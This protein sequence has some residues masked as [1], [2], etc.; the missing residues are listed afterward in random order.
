MRGLDPRIH[1]DR[2]RKQ[3]YGRNLGGFSCI[4]GSN[5]AMTKKGIGAALPSPRMLLEILPQDRVDARLIA[6]S[7][8]AEPAQH[9]GVEPQRHVRLAARHRE[10]GGRPID[11]LHGVVGI[12]AGRQR[13]FRR[14]FPVGFGLATLFHRAQFSRRVAYDMS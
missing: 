5:P 4:A 7:L 8:R 14:R 9:V 2:P 3:S 1:D 11:L 6:P 12:A 13:L 10:F